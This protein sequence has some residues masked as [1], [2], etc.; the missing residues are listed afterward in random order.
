MFNEQDPTEEREK[1]IEILDIEHDVLVEMLRFLYCNEIPKIE[2]MALDLIVA[3]DK[4]NIRDLVN[5]CASNFTLSSINEQNCERI[6][7]IGEQLK[8][9]NLIGLH[10]VYMLTTLNQEFFEKTFDRLFSKKI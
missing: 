5:E 4:Y 2:E 9:G 8:L 6:K 10:K 3:A 7:T 1:I